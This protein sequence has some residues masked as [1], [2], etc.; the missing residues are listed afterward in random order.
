MKDC[1]VLAS[2]PVTFIYCFDQRRRNVGHAKV[3]QKLDKVFKRFRHD[4]TF[5][6]TKEK[7][8]GSRAK[9]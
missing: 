6:I 5:L 3:E 7:S 8:Y 9:V 4:P 1:M 2:I